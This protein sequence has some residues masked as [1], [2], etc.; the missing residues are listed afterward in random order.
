MDSNSRTT[1]SLKNSGIAMMFYVVNLVLQF[2]SRKI[3]LEYLGTEIL[4]LNTTALNLLQFLNLAELGISAAVGFTLYKPLNEND[5]FTINEVITL[6]GHLYRR[7]AFLIIGGAVILMLFFP[8]F[9]RKITLPLWYAYASFGVLLFSS[10]LGYFFNYKQIILSASQQDYKIQYSF[11]SIN[12]IKI[13]VQMLAVYYLDHGYIWWLI[14]EVIFSIIA[15]ISLH[16][17]TKRAFPKLEDTRQSLDEL[18][19]KYPEIVIKIKQLFFHK[20]G[21]FALTQSSPIII[22]AF[23][24]LT[25]VALYGNYVIIITGLTYLVT[26]VFNSMNASVGNLLVNSGKDYS[27][28]IFKE[29]FSLRFTIISIICY[30][31]YICT[32]IFIKIWIGEQYILSSWTLIIMLLI[33]HISLSRLTVESFIYA[34]GLFKDIFAPVIE[35][36]IN[37]GG[38]IL[39]GYF[40]G[41]NGILLGVLLSL[42][43][44]VLGWKPYFLFINEYKGE[45]KFYLTIFFRNLIASCLAIVPS[46]ALIPLIIPEELTSFVKLVYLFLLGTLI[47]S[48]F[49]IVFSII[50]DTGLILFGLRLKKIYENV[51]K[52]R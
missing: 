17:T 20:I 24:S 3:F 43:I 49:V 37:I 28:K 9:F 1:K 26:S 25:V 51:F 12:L 21:S 46:I 5:Q 27:L 15:S 42:V 45:Y 18:K 31:T 47:Y 19:K 30:V 32:P 34:K 23:T 38:S 11:R 35:A 13:L 36:I 2:F 41:L 29:L 14:L 52:K 6:Q 7:I 44:V 48:F 10:L 40:W 33:L 50:A 8:W 16:Y 4:G 22:Y 39:L